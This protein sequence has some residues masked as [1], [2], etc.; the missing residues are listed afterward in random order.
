MGLVGPTQCEARWCSVLASFDKEHENLIKNNPDAT[1]EINLVRTVLVEIDQL[2]QTSPQKN[3]NDV[4]WKHLID[5]TE[6][7]KNILCKHLDGKALFTGML[8]L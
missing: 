6:N 4:T 3:G 2:L 1:K 8:R 5:Q 7:E